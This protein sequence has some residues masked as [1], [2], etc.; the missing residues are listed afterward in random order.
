MCHSCFSFRLDLLHRVEASQP[1]TNLRRQSSKTEAHVIFKHMLNR[2]LQNKSV[3]ST[4]R[5][6]SIF[7]LSN[8]G[9]DSCPHWRC[10]VCWS[11]KTR[12]SASVPHLSLVFLFFF[13]LSL[14]KYKQFN[15]LQTQSLHINK[16]E[17]IKCGKCQ[18][19]KKMPCRINSLEETLPSCTTTG[20]CVSAF[21]D[22]L[23]SQP[24]SGVLIEE[25]T[26]HWSASLCIL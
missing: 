19:I 4:M 12:T 25:R 15:I 2:R 20:V 5:T 3:N 7:S 26:G 22:I 6:Y 23:T 24:Q 18:I 8:K 11:G 9:P 13:L 1:E 21:C 10:Q 17:K 14:L 16:K